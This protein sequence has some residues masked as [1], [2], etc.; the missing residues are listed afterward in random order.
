MT[1]KQRT[2][3]RVVQALYQWLVSGD[4]IKKIEQEFLNQKEGK[5]SKAFFSNLLL[6]I[7]KKIAVLDE[8]INSS[9]DRDI[10]ELGP[11]EKAILYLGVYELKF[12][13]E[14]PFKVVINEAVELSKLYGAE[15]SFKLINSSLDKIA[16]ELRST[17]FV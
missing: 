14:V 1:P 6:N 5:I 15:G 7:P 17:E 13:L 10:D 9:L 2:R 16:P 4:D 8:I 12:Q 3:A 11:T